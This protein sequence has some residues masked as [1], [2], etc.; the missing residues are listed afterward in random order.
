[1]DKAR[2]NRLQT[3][4]N[5]PGNKEHFFKRLIRLREC[6]QISTVVKVQRKVPQ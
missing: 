2:I 6:N 4:G 5:E 1:M 3:V